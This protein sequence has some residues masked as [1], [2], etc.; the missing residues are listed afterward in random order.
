MAE[1]VAQ[2][3]GRGLWVG[4][5]GWVL[6]IRL[7]RDL[8]RPSASSERNGGVV[9]VPHPGGSSDYPADA[10]GKPEARMEGGRWRLDG[11][12]R[13]WAEGA[14]LPPRVLS[15]DRPPRAPRPAPPHIQEAGPAPSES[16]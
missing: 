8:G 10:S 14:G 6:E 7:D 4:G 2:G 16:S 15:G 5:R 1:D 11:A 12:G 13:S 3:M 9:P